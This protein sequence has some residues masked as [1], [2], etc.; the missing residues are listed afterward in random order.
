MRPLV[1]ASRRSPVF[2]TSRLLEIS[3]RPPIA[4]RKLELDQIMPDIFQRINELKFCI[5]KGD[6]YCSDMLK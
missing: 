6:P 2:Q 4:A 5:F 3:G 1:G